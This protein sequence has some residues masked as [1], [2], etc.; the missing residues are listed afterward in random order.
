MLSVWKFP[1][2][3]KDEQSVRMPTGSEILTVQVQQGA[4]YLWALVAPKAPLVARTFMIF[5]TGDDI[6]EEGPRLAY[7]GTVQQGAFMVHVFEKE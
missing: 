2:A 7:I 6:S 1:L 5:G 3:L 4:I